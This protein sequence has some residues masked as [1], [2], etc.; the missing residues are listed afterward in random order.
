MQELKE[1]KRMLEVLDRRLCSLEGQRPPQGL[2][3]FWDA[4]KELLFELESN[5]A[6]RL[7]NGTHL[8]LDL[9]IDAQEFLAEKLAEA[10]IR[11]AA[12]AS[13]RK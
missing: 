3:T 9:S 6:V 4:H 5:G 11:R 2:Q 8:E 13:S 7:T 10:A 1:I 12:H